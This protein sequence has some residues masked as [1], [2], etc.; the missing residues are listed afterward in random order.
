MSGNTIGKLFTLTTA[1][2]SHGLGYVGIVDGCPPGLA[3]DE[4]DLQ[5]ELDRRKPGQ[6]RHTTQRR[7]PDRV[8]ILSGLFE[9]K[10]TGTP[11]GLLIENVDQKSKDYQKIQ[12]KF[13]PG[14]ADYTYWHKY[15]IRDSRGGGRAS[16]RET[17]MRVAAGAVAKKYLTTYYGVSIYAYLS[18]IGSL[19]LDFK[20]RSAISENDFFCADPSRIDEIDAYMTALRKEGESIGARIN[21]VV[22]GS[23]VG[24]GEP[25]FDRL[26][27][28]IAQAMMSINAVK[29]VE[30]GDGFKSVRQKGTE[31]RD[32][33]DENGFRTNHAGGVLGGISTGQ[34]ILV[35]I[36][37]KPTSSIRIEGDTLGTDGKLTKVST[38]GRHDPCVGIRAVPIAEAMMALVLMDH[39]LRQRAQ[40]PERDDSLLSS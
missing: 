2:E 7:E 15:G 14:H 1:G 28:D 16:A 27:A 10:T 40:N 5:L 13:R 35:S 34:D 8:K 25:V 26:D 29:G 37:L 24:W 38:G 21:L 11:I 23:S 6:S 12:D 20:E 30:L 31:H 17:C 19:D 9:G 33:M 18:G 36:A 22:S 32:E 3:L 4:S 39:C